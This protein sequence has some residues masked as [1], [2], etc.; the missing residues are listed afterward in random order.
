MAFH[1]IQSISTLVTRPAAVT[2]EMLRE[3]C[4][5][6]LTLNDL[7]V[8]ETDDDESMVLLIYIHDW[9]LYITKGFLGK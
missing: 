2:D 7:H 6:T 5:H 4:T 1:D 8:N 3:K 9:I